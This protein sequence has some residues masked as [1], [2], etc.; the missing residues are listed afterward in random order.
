MCKQDNACQKE[1]LIRV[2]TWFNIQNQLV[3]L[4]ILKATKIDHLSIVRKNFFYKFQYSFLIKSFIKKRKKLNLR[5]VIYEN[6]T[7]NISFYG[8]K[9]HV[10]SLR[11]GTSNN[12][13]SGHIWSTLYWRF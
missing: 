11:L 8:K 10:L 5:K 1:F 7:V 3:Q 9:L 6:P 13:L 2:W 12:V 4:T